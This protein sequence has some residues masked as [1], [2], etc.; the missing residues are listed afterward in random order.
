MIEAIKFLI[1]H[2]NE[3]WEQI[4]LVIIGF[5]AFLSA[6]NSLLR[7]V[8]PFTAWKWDDNLAAFLG[9]FLANKIFQKK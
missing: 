9:K 6:L 4:L 5:G 7:F 1:S 8:A 2:S 3:I